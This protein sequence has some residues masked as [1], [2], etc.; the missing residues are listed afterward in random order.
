MVVGV[1]VGAVVGVVVR[2]V[3]RAVVRMVVR[4][5]LVGLMG[6]AGPSLTAPPG[7][8]ARVR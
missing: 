2:M 3:V 1:V 8:R 4:V 7:H 5:A 6:Q